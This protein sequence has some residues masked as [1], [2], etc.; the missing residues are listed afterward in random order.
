[1]IPDGIQ[2]TAVGAKG[3]WFEEFIAGDYT[4][5]RP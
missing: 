5:K 3:V 1:M 2:M 4:K